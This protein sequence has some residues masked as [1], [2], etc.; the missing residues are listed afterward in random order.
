MRR[1]LQFAQF[2]L[3]IGGISSILSLFSE[4][5]GLADR[6]LS[7][8]IQLLITWLIIFLLLKIMQLI[9]TKNIQ[10]WLGNKK[11]IEE[12]QR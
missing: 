8:P 9:A 11:L 5:R 3:W 4:S 6:V 7:L 12:D 10:G 1:L 2:Y